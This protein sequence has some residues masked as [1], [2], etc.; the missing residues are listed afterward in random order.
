MKYLMLADR[1]RYFKE[2][3]EGREIMC[4]AFEEVRDEGAK[5]KSLELTV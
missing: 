5:M 2:T 3:E 4:K 1:A